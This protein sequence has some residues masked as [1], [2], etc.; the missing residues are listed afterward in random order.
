MFIEKLSEDDVRFFLESNIK[1]DIEQI[2]MLEDQIYVRLG[3]DEKNVVEFSFK[4]FEVV[5]HN[6]FAKA[7]QDIVQEKWVDFMKNKFDY[8]IGLF[9]KQKHTRKY[10]TAYL[11]NLRAKNA[12][13]CF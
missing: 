12:E 6:I 2:E 13:R 4:D 9:G 8:E 1:M 7:G 11:D 3:L 10:T 5:G